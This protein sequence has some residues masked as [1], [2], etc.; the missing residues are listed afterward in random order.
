[1]ASDRDTRS[2]YRSPLAGRY[3]SKE[4]L[5]NFSERTRIRTWRSFWIHLAEA[6]RELGLDIKPEQI[7][8]MKA[9]ADTN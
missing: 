5:E 8:A 3:A 7:R 9:A 6:Q 1:M 4:M 2:L